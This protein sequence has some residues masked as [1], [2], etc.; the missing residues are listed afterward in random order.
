MEFFNG[1]PL[2]VSD[3]VNDNDGIGTSTDCSVI[4]ALQ[5]GEGKL[6]GITAAGMIQV[7][8]VGA[9]ETKDATRT[10]IKWYV[11]LALFSTRAAAM[12]TGVR[13]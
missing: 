10:R 6:S 3:W 4:Y 1:I 9:L 13:D 2:H 11:G 5:M 8:R 12:L 7:E